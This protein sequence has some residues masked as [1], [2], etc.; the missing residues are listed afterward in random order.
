MESAA[1][2]FVGSTVF[3]GNLVTMA[4]AQHA[5]CYSQWALSS[6]I[7]LCINARMPAGRS[8]LCCFH[9]MNH[10]PLPWPRATA[11]DYQL[12]TFLTQWCAFR[13]L[14]WFD[15]SYRAKSF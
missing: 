10:L 5:G 7:A 12:R 2:P 8:P 4:D 13:S 3:N 11:G 14:M 6:I 15:S 1:R 9:S